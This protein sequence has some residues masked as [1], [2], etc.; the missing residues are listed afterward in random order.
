MFS[1]K[2]KSILPSKPGNQTIYLNGQLKPQ[3]TSE[4]SE[5]YEWYTLHQPIVHSCP[6]LRLE[7]EG[8]Q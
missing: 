5:K 4:M 6:R 1:Y 3:L 2:E 7:L 8:T